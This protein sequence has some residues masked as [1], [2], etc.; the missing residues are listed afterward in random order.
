MLGAG[1]VDATFVPGLGMLGTSL[2]HRGDEYL[3]LHGGLDGYAQGHTTGLPL[4]APWA[5][6]LSTTSY[7]FGGRRVDLSGAHGLHLDPNGLAIHGTMTAQPD[8]IVT[9]VSTRGASAKLRALFAFGEHPD[10]LASFPFPHDLVIEARVEPRGLVMTTSVVATDESPVPVSFGWHPYLVLPGV[11]RTKAVLGLP[12]REHLALDEH[13]IPT[14]ERVR[15]PAEALPLGRRTFDDGYRMPGTRRLV[16]SGGDRVVSLE[17]GRGY[18]FAQVYAPADHDFVA[19][20]PMTA[21]TD[22][23]VTGEHPTVEPGE[24]FSARFR[25]RFG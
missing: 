22:A 23:L 11:D 19:L 25:I 15:E 14:G 12:T 16:L 6:R 18:P 24:R 20:E 9:E 10:L 17:L 13:M 3:S 4:L 8:W 5:N 2:R 21:P 1:D 7:R